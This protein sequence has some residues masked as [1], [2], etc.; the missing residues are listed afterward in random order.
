MKQTFAI[1]FCLIISLTAFSQSDSVRGKQFHLTGKIAEKVRLTPDCGYIAWGTVIVF[2]VTE[3][4]GI[5]YPNKLIGIIITCP[6]FYK[7]N[8]F[9]VGKTYSVVFSDKN[10]ADFGWTIPNKDLLKKNRLSF[11]PYA[12][13]VKKMP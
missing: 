10:Q 6:E 12:V 1:L 4:V 9:E 3:L 11:D 2:Q 7:N 13:E 8:F 5:S